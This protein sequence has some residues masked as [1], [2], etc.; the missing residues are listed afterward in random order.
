MT[1]FSITVAIEAT[2][3]SGEALYAAVEAVMAP[4]DENLDVEPYIAMTRLQA[5]SDERFRKWWAESNEKTRSAGE[6]E[7]TY[8][9][10]ALAWWGGEIDADGNVISTANP[11]AVWDWW[12]VGGRF[13]GEWVLKPTAVRA[14]P[15]EASSFGYTEEIL[16]ARRTDAARKGEI[17]PESVAPSYAYLDLDGK[18]HAPGRVLWFGQSA[19]DMD[20]RDWAGE[21][22]RWFKSL[23]DDVWVVR[24]D[25]HV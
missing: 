5:E 22:T 21:F 12:V 17:E 23:P 3:E 19:D 18:W 25:A 11:D 2:V 1:H 8:T 6:P 10:A 15:S 4:Y 20:E 13:A 24:I 7:K 14:L 16:D 9:Q